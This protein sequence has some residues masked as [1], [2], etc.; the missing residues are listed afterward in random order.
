M[1]ALCIFT[2][3]LLTKGSYIL[4]LEEK[5]ARLERGESDKETTLGEFDI[6]GN[7]SE[8]AESSTFAPLLC[9]WCSYSLSKVYI[10]NGPSPTDRRPKTRESTNE[11]S[12]QNPESR[13]RLDPLASSLTN[14]LSSGQFM[15][16]GDGKLCQ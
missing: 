12:V 8:A 14:P 7:V 15:V 11:Q 13:P 9:C 16:G 3:L 1:P 10:D 6:S 5:L 4:D 2:V